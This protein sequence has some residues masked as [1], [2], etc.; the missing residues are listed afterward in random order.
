MILK[1]EYNGKDSKSYATEENAEKAIKKANLG[2]PGNCTFIV[3]PC[4]E[5]GRFVPLILNG[6]DNFMS[7]ARLGFRTFG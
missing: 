6:G 4:K 3:V 5:T 2:I 7:Y 1:Q